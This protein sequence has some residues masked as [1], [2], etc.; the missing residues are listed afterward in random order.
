MGSDMLEFVASWP[1]MKDNGMVAFIA[2]M[3]KE[4]TP[5]RHWLAKLSLASSQGPPGPE[6]VSKAFFEVAE[7]MSGKPHISELDEVG[8]TSA[9]FMGFVMTLRYLGLIG[10]PGPSTSA[11]HVRHEFTLGK[12]QVPAVW[13]DDESVVRDVVSRA[14]TPDAMRTWN[15]AST[16]RDLHEAASSVCEWVALVAGA[17][18]GLQA[19]PYIVRSFCRKV[20]I[21]RMAH[22]TSVSPRGVGGW[23]FRGE[24]LE[25]GRVSLIDIAG[26]TPDAGKH[27]ETLSGMSAGEASNFIFGRPDWA[28]LLSW[29]ACMWS[30]PVAARGE[31]A[32][33]ELI[34]REASQIRVFNKAAGV[35]ITPAHF[36]SIVAGN[37]VVPA[38]TRQSKRVSRPRAPRTPGAP[39]AK[40]PR[41]TADVEASPQH[42]RGGRR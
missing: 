17:F 12:T 38:T 18:R 23:M 29:A 19:G 15:V 3:V 11:G 32:A 20:I 6:A 16:S 37:G 33:V 28:L 24:C 21:A 26:M 14:S 9:R 30:G 22:E 1:K 35:V 5:V 13:L 25:W 7:E 8:G 31:S 4:P 36:L 42:L 41:R 40:Q 39:I 34:Q 2:Y 10:D 27:L